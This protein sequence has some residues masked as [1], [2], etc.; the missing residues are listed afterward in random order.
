MASVETSGCTNHPPIAAVGRCK[1]CGKPFCSTCQV[2]GPTGKFCSEPCK[3][4]H[5]H[6]VQ[7]AA[8][9]DQMR[10]T[11]GVFGKIV[12]KLRKW[13]VFTVA[14]LIVAVALHFFGVNVP[15]I[16]DIIINNF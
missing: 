15:F 11:S 3:A 4:Q 16:S 7:R 6:F 9:L 14:G 10:S 8:K 2:V 1:Q 13:A 12:D 5:E